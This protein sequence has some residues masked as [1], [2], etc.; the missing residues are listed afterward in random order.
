MDEHII[1]RLTVESRYL[2]VFHEWSFHPANYLLL[3]VGIYHGLISFSFLLHWCPPIP[4][5]KTN[6]LLLIKTNPKF[7][8]DDVGYA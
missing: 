7:E 4:W 8:L 2:S 1:I 6:P 5:K 3:I